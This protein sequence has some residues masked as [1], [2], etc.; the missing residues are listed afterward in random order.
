[1]WNQFVSWSGIVVS[2]GPISSA[3][4][5]RIVAQV[6]PLMFRRYVT[7]P[8]VAGMHRRLPVWCLML[9]LRRY[10]EDWWVIPNDEVGVH[11][12][13]RLGGK[14]WIE[15]D[16]ILVVGNKAAGYGWIEEGK[17]EREML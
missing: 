16:L 6:L 13:R 9:R 4:K 7:E 10:D 3:D 12:S 8:I 2:R 1:M 14:A 15:G 5:A 17:L 11:A